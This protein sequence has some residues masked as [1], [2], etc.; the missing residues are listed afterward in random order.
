[1][2]LLAHRCL[3]YFDV[4]APISAENVSRT[5]L[6]PTYAIYVRELLA[7]EPMRL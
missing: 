2:R 5:D 7:I 6:Y 4:T 3:I 1:M